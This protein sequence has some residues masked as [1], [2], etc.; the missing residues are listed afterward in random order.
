M[1]NK[2]EKSNR[3]VKTQVLVTQVETMTLIAQLLR[4]SKNCC[5]RP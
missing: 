2:A 5:R 3:Q 4:E 1:R